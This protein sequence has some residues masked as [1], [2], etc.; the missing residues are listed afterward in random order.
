MKAVVLAVVLAVVPVQAWAECAWVLWSYTLQTAP[1]HV[2]LLDHHSTYLT[3]AECADGLR[4]VAKVLD[5]R[6][7]KVTGP[8]PGDFEMFADKVTSRDS[9]LEKYF[10]IP[11][12]VDPRGP[13]DGGR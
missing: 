4:A 5:S 12:T 1:T 13:R 9:R 10:C 6:A 3:S 11:D 8:L 7:Y 2:E